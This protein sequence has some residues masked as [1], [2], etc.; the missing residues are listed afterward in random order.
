MP[1]RDR[2]IRGMVASI[3]FKQ[4]AFPYDRQERYAGSTKYPLS[5]MIRFAMDAFLGFSMVLLRFSSIAA[6][7]M[8]LALV[9][10]AAYSIYSWAFLYVVP[11]WTSIM[12]TMI[13]VSFFQLIV[14]SVIGEYVGRI[15]LSTKNRPLFI[16]DAIERRAAS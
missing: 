11:G 16:I 13:L 2:F 4:V 1:E 12:I 10:V 15:Y 8:L 7:G 9:G 3:G 14:L 5:K 6:F